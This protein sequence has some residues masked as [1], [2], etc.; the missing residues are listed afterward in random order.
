MN[1]LLSRTLRD[2]Q[3]HILA[4]LITAG[5]LF[6]TWLVFSFVVGVLASVGLP[7]VRLMASPFS[8]TLV[9]ES[10]FQYLLAV[11]LTVTA[12]YLVGRLTS[13]VFGQQ[14][15]GLFEASLERLPV[16]NKIYTSV[17]QLVDTLMNKNQS[18][19]RVVLIEF[20]LAGQ[21]SIGF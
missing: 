12:F 6:I 15:L 8:G 18:G 11:L 14:M 21:K 10:W 19:Q 2:L 16:V 3:R 4:G 7:L 17:R 13:Q 5:P 9:N 20:P 1:P